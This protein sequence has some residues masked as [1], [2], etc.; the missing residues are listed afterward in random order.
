M[1]MFPVSDSGTTVYCYM[2]PDN[3]S[4]SIL[5]IQSVMVKGT[6]FHNTTK[7]SG[8]QRFKAC[9]KFIANYWVN[10]ALLY[11]DSVERLLR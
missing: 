1:L 9:E 10:D 4:D 8:R 11:Y 2:E 6:F 5:L 7:V 3:T